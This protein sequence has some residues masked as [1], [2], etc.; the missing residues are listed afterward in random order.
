MLQNIQGYIG[1][2]AV[3]ARVRCKF[4]CVCGGG[5]LFGERKIISLE[6]H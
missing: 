2:L 5:G 4:F 3:V 1:Y 6:T